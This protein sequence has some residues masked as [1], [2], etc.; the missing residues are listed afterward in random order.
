MSKFIARLVGVH[1]SVVDGMYLESFDPEANEGR[2]HIQGTP[3]LCRAM[4]FDSKA[5][6]VALWLT[7]PKCRPVRESDGRPNKPLTA[8]HM[9]IEELLCQPKPN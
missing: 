5:E 8:F 9:S 1:P 6:A 7:V 2:G 3:L 4:Q